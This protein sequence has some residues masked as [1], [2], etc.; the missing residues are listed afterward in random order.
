M[1][2]RVLPGRCRTVG[3]SAWPGTHPH[4][5]TM[6]STHNRHLDAGP[7]SGG[8]AREPERVDERAWPRATAIRGAA[9]VRASGPIRAVFVGTLNRWFALRE[10]VDGW[11]AGQGAPT[12]TIAGGGPE[13]DDLDVRGASNPDVHV[14]GK[15][16]PTKFQACCMTMTSVSFRRCEGSGRCCPT[17]S[18][19]TWLQGCSVVHSLEEEPSNELQSAGFGLRAERNSD[20][21]AVD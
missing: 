19:S 4:A 16:H 20:F 2:E 5:A 1:P 17:T 3:L 7:N 15:S 6:D 13:L 10:V 18:L 14:I 9:A 11:P 21:G 12:L 8:H